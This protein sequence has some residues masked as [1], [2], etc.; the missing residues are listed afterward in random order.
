MKNKEFEYSLVLVISIFTFWFSLILYFDNT[1][2]LYKEVRL[3]P[4]VCLS[5]L[6]G[7]FSYKKL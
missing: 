1:S 2:I 6:C 5:T 7:L 3:I 4:I